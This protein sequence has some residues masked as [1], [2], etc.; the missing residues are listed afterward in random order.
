MMLSN[1]KNNNNNKSNKNNDV[2]YEQQQQPQQQQDENENDDD[3][4]INNNIMTNCPN[5]LT[6][7]TYNVGLLRLR[8]FCKTTTI[9]SNPPYVNERFSYMITKLYELITKY[10]VDVL[11]IQECYEDMHYQIITNQ[12]HVH[13]P[14]HSRLNNNHNN[15]NH[16]NH[17]YNNYFDI[18]YHNGLI[19]YSKYPIVS[20]YLQP[21]HN[22][23]T[24]EKYM[25]CKSNLIVDIDFTN[26]CSS[27]NNNNTNDNN[28]NNNNDNNAN[29]NHR[30]CCRTT[31]TKTK[32][33]WRFVNIHTTAGGAIH[34]EHPN[35]DLDRQMELQQ[36]IDSAKVT[37][38]GGIV[39]VTPPPSSTQEEQE[40]Q[41]QQEEEQQRQ[42]EPSKSQQPL[43]SNNNNNNQ[44]DDNKN[45]NNDDRINNNNQHCVGI[46]IGDLNCGP[47]ASCDNFQY[48]L[49][50]G[51]RDTYN[52]IHHS[53]TTTNSTTNSSSSS[54]S[55]TWDPKNIL[56]TM[57]P[58]KHCPGQRCDHILIPK[59]NIIMNQ[60][61]V[62]KADILLREPIVP[63]ITTTKTTTKSI[64]L[65]D[66]YALLIQLVKK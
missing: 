54:S 4:N 61:H 14:Y 57:G 23:S 51:Y 37:I 46:L 27:N 17:Y 42:Q 33:I 1:D 22:V 9:F 50:A 21:Y 58:H 28:N 49:D 29:D 2:Y 66:H 7:V 38:P 47:E 15:N 20:S 11:C 19:I 32:T 35:T 16:N 5:T 31:T 24:M 13:F 41:Q 39:V 45:N 40:E 59:Y 44:N 60:Y 48:V 55:Y 62:Q 26:S 10:D 6:M 8:L 25:A 36:A 65:S 53:F 56:N 30:S 43:S 3:S 34:P 64:T 12:L 63:I 18:R 52:E